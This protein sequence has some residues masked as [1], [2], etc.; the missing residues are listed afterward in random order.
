VSGRAVVRLLAV[1]LALGMV[2]LGALNIVGSL[3]QDSKRV[4]QTYSGVRVVDVHVGAESVEVRQGP[5]DT[6]RLD[7][8]VTWS[9]RTPTVVQRQVGDR[10]EVTS[11]CPFSMG[12]GCGGHVL[13]VVPA[14]TEVHAGS[15]AGSVRAAGLTGSVELSS[16]AG[17][18]SGT[19]LRSRDV[20]AAS[21]AGSTKLAF[22]L[23]PQRV[24]ASSSAGSVEVVVPRGSAAYLVDAGS[25]AGSSNVAVRT[26]PESDRTIRAHSSAGSVTVRYPAR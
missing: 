6:T 3:G 9:L 22:A 5:G 21:S 15:S 4:R 14:G 18:V 8:T 20:T 23:P 26:D 11:H 24:D 2:V 17:S 16:S 7:R 19:G 25:S 1:L 13:L 12:R 10:L